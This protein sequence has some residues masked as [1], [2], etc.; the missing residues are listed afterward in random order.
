VGPHAIEP[1]AV[2]VGT[3]WRSHR[4]V[5][6]G[7]LLAVLLVAVAGISGTAHFTGARWIPHWFV[8]WRP[9]NPSH[10]PHTLRPGTTTLAVARSARGSGPL[11]STILWILATL[12]VIAIGVMVWRWWQGRRAG[13]AK[14]W[15]AV[16]VGAPTRAPAASEIE[17]G[18]PALRTGVE[19]ALEV[20]DEQR[21]PTDAI[22][23]AWLGLEETA[24]ASGISRQPAET[25]TEFTSRVLRRSSAD[26]SAVRTLLRVYLRTR[27]GEHPA[28]DDDVA[29]VRAALEELIRSWPAPKTLVRRS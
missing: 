19:L 9:S 18:A 21:E 17:A 11:G 12:V 15:D 24:E 27:F 2:L 10:P 20:L 14:R 25:P 6:V 22:V 26:D 8:S 13:R 16:T 23:R 4:S 5:S 1:D 29:A 28:T 3:W 7:A